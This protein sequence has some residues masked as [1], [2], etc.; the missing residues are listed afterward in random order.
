MKSAVFLKLATLIAIILF[1]STAY[2]SK[3]YFHA[4]EHYQIVEFA[5]YKLNTHQKNELAW[6]FE[7]KIRPAFQPSICFLL[8]KFFQLSNIS[9]PYTQT[10]FLRLFAGLLAVF[11]IYYFIKNTLFLFENENYKKIY[12]LLSYFLWFIPFISVRFSSETFSGLIFLLAVGV[13]FHYQLKFKYILI[14]ILFGF[15]FLFRFQSAILIIGF[16]AWLYF[17]KNDKL[18]HL[19]KII[20][21]F[22]VI[23]L[24][25]L[26]VD[27]WFYE[28]FVITS[29]NYFKINLIDGAAA[30]FGTSPWY[31]YIKSIL[32]DTTIPIGLLIIL[33][34]I[35]L[36]IKHSRQFLLWIFLP[37]IIIHSIIGHKEERFLFPLIYFIPLIICLAY[38]TLIKAF[39]QKE[40][41]KIVNYIIIILIIPINLM[42][43]VVFSS[44][45]AGAGQMKLT[46]NIYSTYEDKKV[47]I[48]Y[49]S[50]GNP[51][52]PWN[53]LPTKFYTTQN[54]N[55][56][57]IDELCDLKDM[58][59]DSSAI[60]ILIIRQFDLNRLNNCVEN[61][62]KYR[63]SFKQKSISDFQLFLNN[64]Y[65]RLDNQN[66]LLMYERLE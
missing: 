26:I 47:N 5:G 22:I 27:F 32:L 18:N 1:T 43:L 12:I 21:A 17:I 55:F 58:L 8:L 63:F 28:S 50:F 37:F 4:D 38:Q 41:L 66:V 10:F 35:V 42:A 23:F 25:G 2:F 24:F 64:Y 48:I 6:E 52:N 34:F 45:P 65:K 40:N 29:W 56:I 57:K 20:F 36:I 53:G 44:H 39:H 33:S 19:A 9:N 7:S 16:M 60:N 62:E 14:G 59:F 30:K 3:G 15:C 46:E 31:F 54:L 61:I 49:P 11:S 51:Y 13:F